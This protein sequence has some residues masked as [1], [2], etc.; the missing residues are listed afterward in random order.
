V[1]QPR[2]DRLLGNSV[3]K[4]SVAAAKGTKFAGAVVSG[5]TFIDAQ[6]PP[7]STPE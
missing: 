6:E 5:S 3:P 4:A 7:G 2:I 1:G